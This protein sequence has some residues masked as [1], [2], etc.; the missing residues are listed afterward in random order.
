MS[1]LIKALLVSL[2]FLAVLGLG[3]LVRRKFPQNPELS[4]KTV[5]FLGGLASLPFPFLFRSSWTVLALS[6]GFLL[7]IAWGKTSSRL[8]A[9][10]EVSRDSGGAFY[11]PSAI[12]LTFL[13]AAGN[14]VIYIIAIL[15]LTVSDTFAAL[16][17]L[18]YGSLKY[19]V[20]GGVKSLEGSLVFFFITFLC[21]QLPL[22]L[23]TG[24]GRLE[25]VLIA[26]II[27]LLAT[28]FEAVSLSGS[29]NLL[30]P[31]GVYY[32]LVKLLPLT[33]HSLFNQTLLLLLMIA[34]TALISRWGKIFKISGL[35]GMTILNY[36][37]WSLG[38]FYWFL[39]LL[40]AQLIY[41]GLILSF[42][43]YRGKA[44]L[45]SF[46]IKPLLYTALLPTLLLFA[47][48]TF[49]TPQF[50]Y[51]PYLVAITAQ[52]AVIAD[53]FWGVILTRNRDFNYTN[54]QKFNLSVLCLGTSLGLIAGITTGLNPA[55]P[56]GGGVWLNLIIS[57]AAAY[58]AFT[59][60][61]GH[62]APPKADTPREHA[63]RLA[64]SLLGV[65][66]SFLLQW[67]LKGA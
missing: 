58:L 16:S 29:D 45:V 38:G 49:K 6:L 60:T 48:N 3:E 21:V 27:A 34:V 12:Y 62:P 19:E 53:F 35:I 50:F 8:K 66:L 26:L 51:L 32:L 22:L 59:L 47:A 63:Y 1:E 37:S 41:A 42:I 7:L 28:G 61:F 36:A 2:V 65:G 25:C 31:L 52:I 11:F 56:Q 17:G 5:H 57:T 23:L 33:P 13:L 14:P 64:A 46:Q 39:P 20:E 15:T 10:H 9:V 54:A 30:V 55:F 40:I 18:R 67:L 24:P 44:E 43:R 4:R